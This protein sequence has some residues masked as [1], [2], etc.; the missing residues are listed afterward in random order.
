MKRP[1]YRNIFSVTLIFIF[2]ISFIETVPSRLEIAINSSA[3]IT[4]RMNLLKFGDNVNSS[5]LYFEQEDTKYIIPKSNIHVSLFN[6]FRNRNINNS[7]KIYLVVLKHKLFP[8][9]VASILFTCYL[10]TFYSN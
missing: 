3:N 9:I 4:C 10:H 1:I 5:S 7:Y 6:F 8:L 2:F